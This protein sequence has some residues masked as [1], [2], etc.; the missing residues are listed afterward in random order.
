MTNLEMYAIAKTN[1]L[2]ED[3]AKIGEM[4]YNWVEISP[5]VL[6]YEDYLIS[7]NGT[8]WENNP[9]WYKHCS[10]NLPSGGLTVKISGKGYNENYPAFFWCDSENNYINGYGTNSSVVTDY[11]VTL[12]QN[13]VKLY[14]NGVNNSVFSLS[15]KVTKSLSEFE[16]NPLYGKKI[17]ANGDS[18]MYGL[19]YEG[20]VLKLIADR[21]NMI[22]NNVAV[23]GGTLS[24]GSNTSVHHICDTL[25][26]MDSDADYYIIEGGYNDYNYNTNLLGEITQT[27]TDTVSVNTVYGALEYIFRKLLNDYPTKK[28]GFIITHKILNSAYTNKKFTMQQLHDAVVNVCKKYSIPYCDLFEESHFN[29]ELTTFRNYTKNSDGV[30]PTKLGYELFYLPKV[31]S[32]LKTL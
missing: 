26:N 10:Y 25:D 13:A 11:E 8:L 24:S 7:K 4:P 27:M 1:K 21:N 3:V 30:H 19:G 5:L 31:E 29:T 9:T 18:I 2:A 16:S 32:W 20:G 23:N 15:Y 12:P 6:P 22:L 28:I 17:S 14:I